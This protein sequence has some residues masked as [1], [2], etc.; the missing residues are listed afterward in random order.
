MREIGPRR[1]RRRHRLIDRIELLETRVGAANIYVVGY[2]I[3]NSNRDTIV[4]ERRNVN[5][6]W[7]LGGGPS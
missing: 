1:S 3:C 6:T 4:P 5:V 2:A 7:T